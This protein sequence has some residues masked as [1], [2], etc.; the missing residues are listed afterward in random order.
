MAHG[1]LETR[2]VATGRMQYLPQLDGLR[3]IAVLAVMAHHA[4]T[5]IGGWIGVQVFFVLSGYLITSLLVRERESTGHIKL[6]RFWLRRLLRLYPPL[7]AALIVL[8]PLGLAASGSITE[9]LTENAVAASYTTNLFGLFTGQSAG[10]WSHTWTLAVEE[11]FYLLWPLAFIIVF[12]TKARFRI[13]VLTGLGFLS[14]LVTALQVVPGNSTFN[15]LLTAGGL[16]LGCVLA[17]TKESWWTRAQHRSVGFAGAL[18]LVLAL[19]FAST[20]G[21]LRPGAEMLA[22]LGSLLFVAH[23]ASTSGKLSR[24]LS[25]GPLVYLGRISYELYLW[26][27]PLFLMI[28]AIWPGHYRPT[29]LLAYALAFGAS[30]LSHQFVSGPLNR[31]FKPILS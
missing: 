21:A 25:F 13:I 24:V 29:I 12:A 16:I 7:L 8:F 2:D 17:L 4:Y 27:F 10:A 9:Y 11:Q 23:I 28:L 1:V 20:T 5:F 22:V 15:P 19:G 14:L 26:H 30:I 6:G 3:A 18:S 31:R